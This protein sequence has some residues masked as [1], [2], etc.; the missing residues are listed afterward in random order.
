MK[1]EMGV[2]L[3]IVLVLGTFGPAAAMGPVEAG[4]KGGVNIA[5][6]SVDP[7][8]D[9]SLDARTGLALGGFV[10]FPVLPNLQIQ[11]EAL[12]MMKGAEEDGDTGTS[13]YKLN[14]IEVPVLAKLGFMNQSPAH[15]S[16]FLG[17]SLAFNA[18]SKAD[19]AGAGEI[20]VKD[21]TK[22][23]DVGVVVGAGLDFQNLGIDV[24]YTRG[25]TN[26]ADFEGSDTEVTNSVVS[27]MGSFR[28]L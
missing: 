26:T 28:F 12:F 27:I 4:I 25:L 5:N 15:P 17:P 1:R 6:Q 16:I 18:T 8:N 23:V 20:D 10:G 22:P 24:R 2:V 7:D 11:P 3:A 14:Y 9:T 19:L 13:S 21:N